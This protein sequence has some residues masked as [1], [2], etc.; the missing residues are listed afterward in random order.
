MK[1]RFGLLGYLKYIVDLIVGLSNDAF[2]NSE[3]AIIF[4]FVVMWMIIILSYLS[5]IVY[6]IVEAV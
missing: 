1:K 2:T 3:R 4:A 5:I 6:A